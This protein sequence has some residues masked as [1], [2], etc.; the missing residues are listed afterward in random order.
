MREHD[1][2]VARGRI[3]RTMHPLSHMSAPDDHAFAPRVQQAINNVCGALHATLPARAIVDDMD[4]IVPPA[5]ELVVLHHDWAR[6]RGLPTAY[7]ARTDQPG[8]VSIAGQR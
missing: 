7:G 3:R 8:T 1:D 6:R 4:G 2:P 5:T